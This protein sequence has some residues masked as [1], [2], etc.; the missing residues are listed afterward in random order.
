[1][2]HWERGAASKHG[3]PLGDRKGPLPHKSWAARLVTWLPLC[4]RPGGLGLGCGPCGQKDWASQVLWSSA[5]LP[6]VPSPPSW[7]PGWTSIRRTSASPQTFPA[8]SNWWPMCNSTCPAQTWNAVPTCSWPS[9]RTRSAVTLSPRVRKAGLGAWEPSGAGGVLVPWCALTGGVSGWQGVG[10][11]RG[12]LGEGSCGIIGPSPTALSPAP[13][14][15]LRPPPEPAPVPTPSPEPAP[16]P[17]LDAD[18]APV[19]EL[20]PAPELAA[21][22]EEVLAQT[23]ELDAASVPAPSPE[24]AWPLPVAAEDGLGEER[25][26]LLVFPPELVAEQFTLMDAV[27]G[28]TPRGLPPGTCSPGWPLPALGLKPQSVRYFLS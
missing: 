28:S 15:T 12:M 2:S 3:T 11:L 20:E 8:S 18:P 13:V 19:L 21:E 5:Y 26:H 24:P 25:P 4:A 22:L 9:W 6:P 27:S 17:D 10:T 23:L 16:A 7:A 1:M 14:P